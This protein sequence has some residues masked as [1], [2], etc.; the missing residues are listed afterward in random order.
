MYVR[1]L[2]DI[3]CNSNLERANAFKVLCNVHYEYDQHAS[4]ATYSPSSV[5]ADLNYG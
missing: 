1:T 5:E 4:F 3:I 2:P